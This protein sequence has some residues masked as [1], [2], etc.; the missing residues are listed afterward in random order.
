M[1]FEASGAAEPLRPVDRRGER[2]LKVFLGGKLAFLDAGVSADCLVRNLSR[3]GA[4]VELA[5]PTAL[6]IGPVLI[7]TKHARAHM[8]QPAWVFGRRAGL[9]LT[10]VWDLAQPGDAPAWMRS[11]WLALAPS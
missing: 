11:L 7:I 6:P 10:G 5:Q 9:R 2:R 1:S 4:A 8:T 3:S